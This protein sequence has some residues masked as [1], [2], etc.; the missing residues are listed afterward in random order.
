MPCRRLETRW[1]VN[2]LWLTP[3]IL[4]VLEV[5]WKIARSWVKLWCC[6][7]PWR[8]E[9]PKS[10]H[11]LSKRTC[12][13]LSYFHLIAFPTLEAAFDVA[14]IASYAIPSL[15]AITTRFRMRCRVRTRSLD[16]L[17]SLASQAREAGVIVEFSQT[18]G[19]PGKNICNKELPM[20]L[21]NQIARK[22][23][24]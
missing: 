4:V 13:T 22:K 23:H 6:L 8:L 3:A 1:L 21:Q 15:I 10:P 12:K 5:L 16:I 20:P 18:T 7:S 19:D 14:V 9:T 24:K 17:R 11:Y 2:I